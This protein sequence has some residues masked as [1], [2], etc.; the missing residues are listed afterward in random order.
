MCDKM[1]AEAKCIFQDFG[2]RAV[3]SCQFLGGIIDDLP[4]RIEYVNMNVDEWEHY[5][6]LL[7]SVRGDPPQEA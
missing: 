4:G 5:G 3:T 2:V 6:R 7:V 1:M